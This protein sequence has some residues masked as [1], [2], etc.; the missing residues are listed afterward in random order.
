MMN[1]RGFRG[2]FDGT[3]WK[4]LKCNQINFSRNQDCYR[5]GVPKRQAEADANRAKLA[6]LQKQKALKLVAALNERMAAKETKEEGAEV[7]S[8]PPGL[9]ATEDK[10]SA[11]RSASRSKDRRDRSRSYSQERK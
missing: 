8:A 7:E 5:C 3:E 1:R 6:I 9:K 4:C 11:S 2:G 10:K